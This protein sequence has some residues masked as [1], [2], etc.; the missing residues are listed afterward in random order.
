MFYFVSFFLKKKGRNNP[1][2]N[3]G[4]PIPLA[5]KVIITVIAREID[6]HFKSKWVLRDFCS[7]F[8][9]ASRWV[10]APQKS[11]Y[12]L[13]S[14][15]FLPHIWQFIFYLLF[16]YSSIFIFINI[17]GQDASNRTFF[18]T[19]ALR[20]ENV[21]CQAIAIKS[22]WFS[23]TKFNISSAGLPWERESFKLIWF[24]LG[25]CG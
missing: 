3:S 15:K 18:N 25:S 24:W 17:I 4:N 11:Q 20:L 5:T 14:L 9:S 7:K 13:S 23:L 8:S 10:F 16:S 21:P 12:L 19:E 6:N 22:L 2:N 1:P